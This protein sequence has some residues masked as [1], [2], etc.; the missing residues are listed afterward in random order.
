[1]LSYLRKIRKS[2]IE[3]GSTKRYLLYAV[4]EIAL[5]VIGILIALQVNDWNENRK[6]GIQEKT[7][8]TELRNTIIADYDIINMG[9][10]G[11]KKTQRSCTII[12]SHLEQNLSYHDSLALHF[13]RTNQWWRILIRTNAFE[14]LKQFGMDFIK[15]DTTKN[16]I[17][18]LYERNLSFGVTLDERQSLFHYTTITP[19]LI[20]L[21]ESIDKTWNEP[22]NGNVPLD[23]E[24]LKSNEKYKTILRTT[25]GDRAYYNEWLNGTLNT[26]QE[27]ESRLLHEI[28]LK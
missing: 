10:D 13:E 28:Q 9:I 4:G 6:L 3:A 20:E 2:L 24:K 22:K 19:I 8:L 15:D 23:Y 5:V 17:S 26:M 21:F 11:N 16:K 7:L 12:L 27:L 25:I 18:D 14:R 1:M